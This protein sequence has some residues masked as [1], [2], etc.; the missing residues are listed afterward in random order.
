QSTLEQMRDNLADFDDFARPFRDYLYWEQH[1]FN[2]PACWASR[3]VFEAIDGVDKFSEDMRTL[4]KDLNDVDAVLPQMLAQFPPIIAVAKSMQGTLL[5]MH[6]SFSGLVTQMAQLT[7]TASA[8]GQAF[9][10][11]RSGDY[12]YLPPEAFQNPDFQRGLKLF[13]SPDGKAARFIITHDADPATPAGI[14]AVT[15]ELAAAHQAVKGTNLTDA[16]F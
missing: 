4:I 14:S 15:P 9:D 8:M 7:D 6:S 10:A 16:K 2:I 11:S 5:T 3:S 13:L 1:C 12:F